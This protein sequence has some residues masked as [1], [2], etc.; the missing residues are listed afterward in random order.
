[1][2]EAHDL[3]LIPL[4]LLAGALTTLAGLGGGLM[5]VAALS[6]LYDPRLALAITAPALM[7][8]N[9]HRAVIYR[10]DVDRPVALRVASAGFVSALIFGFWAVRCPDWL[11]RGLLLAATAFALGRA[12]GH[13]RLVVERRWMLPMGALVGAITATSGGG[14]AVLA[15]T[16]L[17]AGLT[18]ETYVST[19]AVCALSVHVAR[20]IAYGAGG[21]IDEH[22]L[23]RAALLAVFVLAGNALGA[24]LRPR[25]EAAWLRKVEVGALVVVVALTLV[26][27][28]R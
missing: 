7:V 22:I 9:F 16:L 10:A 25:L 27:I 21:F 17:A 12:S 4:G 20:V 18:G 13:I 11:L 5:L 14:P 3:L 6:L 28:G 8:G 24:K 15:P 23:A 19:G 26:G 2:L 1:M